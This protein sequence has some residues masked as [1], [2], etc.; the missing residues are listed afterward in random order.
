MIVS[1]L[2]KEILDIID[3]KKD[4]EKFIENFNKIAVYNAT[5]SLLE[6]LPS[7]DRELLFEKMGEENVEEVI[8]DYFSN[9]S[10]QDEVK[11]ET[12]LALD[13][14]LEEVLPKLDED[15]RNKV[16]ELERNALV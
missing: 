15:R 10:V 7:G 1:E 6:K 8:K 12:G 9:D 5:L 16:L 14:F 4:P 2:I 13:L 11:K 3:Y